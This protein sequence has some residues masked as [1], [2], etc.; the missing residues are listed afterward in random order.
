MVYI[1][2]LQIHVLCPTF[3]LQFNENDGMP[4][5]ICHQCVLHVSKAYTFIQKCI[6]SDAHLRRYRFEEKP[7]IEEDQENHQEE[8]KM[9]DDKEDEEQRD[10]DQLELEMQMN[11][12]TD[13]PI[14]LDSVDEETILKLQS[15]DYPPISSTI[16]IESIE[17]IDE[18]IESHFN[19]IKIEDGDN[20]ANHSNHS[21][22]YETET[23]DEEMDEQEEDIID[24]DQE[25]I[26]TLSPKAEVA[27]DS[28]NVEVIPKMVLHRTRARGKNVP[29]P[30]YKCPTCEKVL[31]NYS[32]YK[33]HMQLHS[34]DTPFLCSDCGAGFRTRNAYDGHMITHAKLNPNTCNQCGKSY[35]QPASLR[36]HMLTHSG[37]KPFTCDICGK[38]MTQKSG[39][40]VSLQFRLE[41][42]AVSILCIVYKLKNRN[43]YRLF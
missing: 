39:Y 19:V 5:R 6:T 12:Q 8:Y 40:K 26:G 29:Q 1:K 17:E 36:C 21:I 30:P 13:I 10:Q 28:D 14:D 18:E 3:N 2:N 11:S 42:V 43:C 9:Y 37:E 35:R 15:T 32:S 41:P 16:H 20:E 4:D 23:L 24:G 7:V 25:L 33:Y 31:S 27:E 22:V 38:G 34:N